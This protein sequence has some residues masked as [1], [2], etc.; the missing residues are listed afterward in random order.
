MP[1]WSQ[2]PT[3]WRACRACL[4]TGSSQ[5]HPKS[6]TMSQKPLLIQCEAA[7]PPPQED[8]RDF[9]AQKVVAHIPDQAKLL[10]IGSGSGLF[11][12]LTPIRRKAAH[13]FGTDPSPEILDNKDVDARAVGRME[14]IDFGTQRFDGAF[15][16]NVIEHIQEPLPFLKRVSSLLQPN[17]WFWSA[18]PNALHPFC[19]TSRGLEKIGLKG[20]FHR[21]SQLVK[22]R[23][24]VNEYPSYYRLCNPNRLPSMAAQAGFVALEMYLLHAGWDCYFPRLLKPLPRFYD[25]TLAQ[26]FPRGRL[27]LVYGLRTAP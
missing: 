7:Q 25:A 9:F 20:L 12:K 19:K 2:C 10:E 17:S 1:R 16:Y 15:A 11:F 8:Y 3:K 6:F 21:H 24:T 14:E 23:H 5:Q 18:S 13:I 4:L 27:V 22:G 26:W